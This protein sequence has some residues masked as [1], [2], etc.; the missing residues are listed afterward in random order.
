V[1][2]Q[3]L[4]EKKEYSLLLLGVVLYALYSSPIHHTYYF[5]DETGYLMEKQYFSGVEG[6]MKRS[7]NLGRPITMLAYSIM[8]K[9]ANIPENGMLWIRCLQFLASYVTSVLFFYVLRR[10]NLSPWKSLFLVIFIWSQPVLQCFHGYSM[11]SPYFL[12]V[13]CSYLAFL[14]ALNSSLSNWRDIAFRFTGILA[15]FGIGWLTFQASPFCALAPLAFYVLSSNDDWSQIRRKSFLLIGALLMSMISFLICYKLILAVM[16]LKISPRTEHSLGLFNGLSILKY[17]PMFELSSYL[18]PFEWWNYLF[19]VKILSDATFYILTSLSFLAWLIIF[20]CSFYLDRKSFGNPLTIKKY[21]LVIFLILLTFSPLIADRFSGR[22]HVYIACV[23]TLVLIG[24]YSFS[25]CLQNLPSM[26][27][28]RNIKR[29]AVIILIVVAAGAQANV[30]RGIVLPGAR[31][32]SFIRTEIL[33]QLT[34]DASRVVVITE[35]GDFCSREPCHSFMGRRLGIA[36]RDSK[37]TGRFYQVILARCGGKVKTPVEFTN[38][39]KPGVDLTN[40]I[41]IDDRI[42]GRS[43]LLL[44]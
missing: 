42:L 28:R 26:S 38:E 20:Y 4:L 32:Y 25:R 18:G 30:Y 14:I 19:P 27:L 16:P 23:P 2:V 33:R 6:F 15:L 3:K 1:K 40:T 13:C 37:S 17:T 21:C 31:F 24:F 35:A 7:V 12:G 43:L 22:A 5:A 41:V 36:D 29:M 44:P 9:I 10:L 39:I 34:P 11:L 8:N